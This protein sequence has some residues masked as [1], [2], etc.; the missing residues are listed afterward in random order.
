MSTTTI[1]R[2]VERASANQD[3]RRPGPA[4]LLLPLVPAVLAVIAWVLSNIVHTSTQVLHQT[5]ALTAALICLA[6]LATRRDPAA[7]ATTARPTP[8]TSYIWLWALVWAFATSIV[9]D[10]FLSN[11]TTD[12]G[13]I[14]GIA[15]FLLAHLGF[16][17]YTLKR[18]AFRWPVFIVILVVLLA[19]YFIFFLPS[20]TLQASPAMAIAVLAY[21]LVSCFSLAA[22]IDLSSRSAARWI[23]TAGIASLVISD[24]CIAFS[25]FAGK[26]AFSAPIMP[27]YF[28]AHVL[29]VLSVTVEFTRE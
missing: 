3:M 5:V 29:V 6:L 2:P 20:P 23:F 4:W 27:L 21:L 26:A 18:V 7:D 13:Y 25:D 1:E 14:L 9:G 17:T 8:N 10:L 12:T 28:L 15:F 11:H 24:A 19:L 16:L 22:T